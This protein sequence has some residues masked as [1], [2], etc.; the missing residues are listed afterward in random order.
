MTTRAARRGGKYRIGQVAEAVGLSRQTIHHYV[1][2]GLI[3]PVHVTPGGHRYFAGS[4]F[5]RIDEIQARKASRTL[6]EQR[7][8]ALSRRPRTRRR[9]A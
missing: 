2:L 5:R 3:R 1:E 4:V 9:H 8:D 7:D 6:A